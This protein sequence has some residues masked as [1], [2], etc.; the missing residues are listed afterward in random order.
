[1]TKCSITY[2]RHNRHDRPLQAAAV[3]Q[4]RLGTLPASVTTKRIVLTADTLPS[5]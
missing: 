5:P 2:H 3:C 1:M 4:T